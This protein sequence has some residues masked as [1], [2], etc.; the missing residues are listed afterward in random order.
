MSKRGYCHSCKRHRLMKFL[1]RNPYDKS[2]LLCKD[3]EGC[4]EVWKQNRANA[5]AENDPW[6]GP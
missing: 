5:I 6:Y 1:R 4:D 3:R 2:E